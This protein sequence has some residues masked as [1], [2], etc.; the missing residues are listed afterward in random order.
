MVPTPMATVVPVTV[1]GGQW[2]M[3]QGGGMPGGSM[4]MGAGSMAQGGVMPV[5]VRA[6]PVH[7][8]PIRAQQVGGW[9]EVG[10]DTGH[11]R[12]A[13]RAQG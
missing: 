12:V 2:S 4:Q 11:V 10:V 13:C 1:P 9:P 5:A 7:V 8:N 3:L 6:V